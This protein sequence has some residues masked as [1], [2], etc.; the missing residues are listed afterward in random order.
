MNAWGKFLHADKA[1]QVKFGTQPRISS[2]I[3]IDN[4]DPLTCC[5]PHTVADDSGA[6]AS[7][8]GL[9][10]DA[11]ALLGGPRAKRSLLIIVRPLPQ[12]LHRS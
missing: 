1:A 11:Q 7:A 5:R 10:F 4:A 8:T 9:V 6:F 3:R 12:R 2:L